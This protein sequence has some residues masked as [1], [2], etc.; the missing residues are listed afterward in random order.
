M[1]RITIFLVSLMLLL[2]LSA[3]V[4]A[5]LINMGD[6]TIYDTDLQLTWLQDANYANSTGYD[7]SLYGFDTL[8][9]MKWNDAKAWANNLVFA[10]FDNWRLPT[11]LQPDPS[12][13]EQTGGV[14]EGFN[15]TGSDMG[16]LYYTELGNPAHPS[17][18][19]TGAFTNLQWDNYWSE[20]EYAPGANFGWDFSFFNGI[21]PAVNIDY[22][23]AWAVRPGARP[24]S[25]P[26]P[27]TLLL[28][29]SGLAGI[30]VWRKR[31]GRREG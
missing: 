12:C 21:Q 14:S 13:N 1:K 18:I 8:G 15:C 30:V 10:G 31:L 25:V 7:D 22:L 19:N 26:E 9:K 23:Y 29:G 27:T 16:H 20:T 3:S 11:T 5:A 6:G 28:L 2:G 24:T 4:H 17:L